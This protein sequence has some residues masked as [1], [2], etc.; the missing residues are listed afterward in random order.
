[1]TTDITLPPLGAD[2]PVR[3]VENLFLIEAAIKKLKEIKRQYE[4]EIIEQM[5]ETGEKEIVIGDWKVYVTKEKTEKITKE[6][7]QRLWSLVRASIGTDKQELYLGLLAGGASA[8]KVGEVKTMADTMGE[9][10]STFIE[11]TFPEDLEFVG[12]DGKKTKK[13]PVVLKVVNT[14]YLNK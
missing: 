13:T 3:M 5:R 12:P 2:A 7:A 6:G 11:T 9:K 10:Q 8:F 4:N 1:M 14:K